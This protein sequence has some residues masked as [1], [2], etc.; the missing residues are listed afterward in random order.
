MRRYFYFFKGDLR[1]HVDIFLS[2]VNAAEEYIPIQMIT[3]LPVITY[4]KQRSLVAHYRSKGVKI[5]AVPAPLMT[6]FFTLYFLVSSIGSE[7][8][9]VHLRKQ[10]S[11]PLILAK[12]FSREKFSYVT[13]MEGDPLSE[14]DYLRNHPYKDNYYHNVVRDNSD[15]NRELEEKLKEAD[16]ILV[17]TN[18]LKSLFLARYSCENVTHRKFCV[19][20]TGFDSRKFY[21]D[22]SLRKKKR[23]ELRSED[24]FVVIFTGNVIYSWQNI[25]STIDVFK[26]IKE[27][28]VEK[29]PYLIL[30][31]REDGHSI[32]KEFIEK[33][34]LSKDDYLLSGVSHDEINSYLNAAD[35]GV[36]LRDDHT[37]NK[38]ASPGKLGE[39][40]ATGIDVLTTPYIGTYS[41]P[42]V[43]NEIGIIVDDFRDLDYVASEIRHNLMRRNRGEV[44]EWARKHFS[45]Q[46]FIKRYIDF[47]EHL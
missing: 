8:V 28:G 46:R 45:S 21:F 9:V 7:K 30:L 12:K 3:G 27:R 29:N 42:M 32:A 17:V 24:R 43:K 44:S 23:E 37:M 14:A 15:L 35:M 19:L 26:C 22:E 36:L 41:A 40:L 47:L 20:P 16:G 10:S 34:G 25:K 33:A 31:I 2:W 1:K 18:E 6:I 11:K 4:Y 39:Y 13:E 38:V 5:Y